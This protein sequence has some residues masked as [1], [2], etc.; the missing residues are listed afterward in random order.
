MNASLIKKCAWTG[1]AFGILALSACNHYVDKTNTRIETVLEKTE[2]YAERAQIPD[3]PEPVDTVRM[4]NDIWL[5][6]SSVKIMEGDALPASFERDDSITLAITNN[7]SL[8]VLANELTDLT[9][10]EVRLDDLK[11]ENELPKEPIAVNYSGK[12]SGLLNYLSNR[13]GVWWRYKNGQISFFKKRNARFHN[14]R[15]TDRNKNVC[16][17]KRYFHGDRKK[18]RWGKWQFLIVHIGKFSPVG[19]H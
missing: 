6:N 15:A 2:M 10:I 12:L 17:L 9:G 8:A 1:F 14:L 7:E 16:G 4:N 3:L 11:A 19:Q 18:Q 13:Y 5:G